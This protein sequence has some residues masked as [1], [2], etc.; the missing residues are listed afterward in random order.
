MSDP[1]AEK[2]AGPPASNEVDNIS[3]EAATEKQEQQ[4][5]EKR[6]REYK[7]FG[8]EEEKPTRTCHFST[9]EKNFPSSAHCSFLPSFYIHIRGARVMYWICCFI[10]F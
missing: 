10:I 9:S 1:V 3:K 8:H 7:D 5:P 6:K 4:E 2:E